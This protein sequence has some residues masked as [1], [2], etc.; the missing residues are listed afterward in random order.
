MDL[1]LFLLQVFVI[2]FS[3]AMQPGPVTATVITLGARNRYAGALLAL[4]H[5]I[6]ELPI[7]ILIMLGMQ[8]FFESQRTQITIGLAGGVFL[9]IM[10]MQMISR[11]RAGVETEAKALN[12]KPVL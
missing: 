3:G 9:L 11:L 1:L 10:G 12:A 4:G 7:M 5:A 6:I 8:K 2:S